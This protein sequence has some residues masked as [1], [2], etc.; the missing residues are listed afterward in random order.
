MA[1]LPPRNHRITFEAAAEM[2]RRYRSSSKAWP[3]R[4]GAFHADQ[5]RELLA[6]KGCAALRV[7]YG[8]NEKD[9]HV[10][11]LIGADGDDKDMKGGV[12]LEVSFPCP[13]MCGDGNG[14][15]G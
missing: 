10:L 8:I 2:T 7:W 11:I 15:N 14:L 5:V 4:A 12:L 3:V 9:E 1:P 6:Q 13:P